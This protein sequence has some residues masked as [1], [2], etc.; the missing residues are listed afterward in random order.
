MSRWYERTAHLIRGIAR[1]LWTPDSHGVA[2]RSEAKIAR[3]VLFAVMVMAALAVVAAAV[4][5]RDPRLEALDLR[6]PDT[7]LAKQAVVQRSDL[8]AGWTRARPTASD[9]Q[10]PDCPGYR[11]DFSKFTITGQAQSQF[12][13]PGGL[14]SV[15]SRVEVYASRRDARGDFA[16]STLS[17]VARCLGV[18]MR[19]ETATPEGFTNRLV[20]ARR[21]SAPRLGERAAAYRVVSELSKAGTT[22]RL[23]TDVVI[24]L[25]GRSIGGIFFIGALKRV[26]RQEPIVA[27]MAARLR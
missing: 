17:P 15:L 12:S 10:A 19:G 23:H 14:V 13:A 27:R 1:L 22:V 18:M 16:L 2:V 20:S 24:V 26:P 8:G 6:P 25:R 11:P 4:G 7:R 21:V 9:E 3:R 5:A